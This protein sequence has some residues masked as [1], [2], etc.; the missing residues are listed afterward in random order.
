MPTD[1]TVTVP[2]SQSAP[3][4]TTLAPGFE[5]ILKAAF[6]SF[7]GSGSASAF[8]PCLRILDPSGHVVGQYVTD[9]TVA[10]GS[11]ADVS[12]AP[13]LRAA[14]GGSGSGITTVASPNGTLVITN[15]TG[16]TADLDTAFY[17]VTVSASTVQ[18]FTGAGL[19]VAWDTSLGDTSPGSTM[20]TAGDPTKL[21]A[22][23]DGLYVSTL[24]LA[25][26]GSGTVEAFIQGSGHPAI[27]T[28]PSL[29][30]SNLYQWN[31][32]HVAHYSAGDNAT[33]H[34]TQISGGPSSV[35]AA[36]ATSYFSLVRVA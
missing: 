5:I 19:I 27:M 32:P 12:F 29:T 3:L 10:A 26:G 13:F 18:A 28:W 33:A 8:L 22:P 14:S 21:I 23:N 1:V 15:P 20:W 24:S 34:I 25:F 17:G 6:A 30:A 16:P 9:S 2:G 11:S 36:G 4:A 35:N 31:I 7:N